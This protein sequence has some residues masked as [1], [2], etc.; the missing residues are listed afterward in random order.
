MAPIN[1][2]SSYGLFKQKFNV[3]QFENTFLVFEAIFFFWRQ[4][5]KVEKIDKKI[6]FTTDKRKTVDTFVIFRP[7]VP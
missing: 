4:T 5:Q 3:K 6:A 7:K 1:K 2:H